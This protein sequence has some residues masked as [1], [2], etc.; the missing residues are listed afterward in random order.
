MFPAKCIKV[1]EASGFVNADFATFL[2]VTSSPPL[3]SLPMLVDNLNDSKDIYA[4]IKQVRMAF[5]AQTG[6]VHRSLSGPNQTR[7]NR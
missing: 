1:S 3:P 2:V 6:S 5:V 4:F 7:E